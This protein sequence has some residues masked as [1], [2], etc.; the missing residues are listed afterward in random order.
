MSEI[1]IPQSLVLQFTP[2]KERG[3]YKP[4]LWSYAE[5]TAPLGRTFTAIDGTHFEEIQTL[6]R[7]NSKGQRTLAI[8][9]GFTHEQPIVQTLTAINFSNNSLLFREN[10]FFPCQKLPQYYACGSEGIE[11][12]VLAQPGICS[13]VVEKLIGMFLV[14]FRGEELVDI[15]HGRRLDLYELYLSLQKNRHCLPADKL[16][17]RSA[18]RAFIESF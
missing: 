8:S 12:V 17:E 13:P 18:V 4:N 15:M 10:V 7:T 14:F 16:I 6:I 11:N 5:F 2:T 3:L 9:T 1:E